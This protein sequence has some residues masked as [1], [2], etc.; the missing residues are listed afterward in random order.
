MAS[1]ASTGGTRELQFWVAD[2]FTPAAFAG[3]Q[4]AVYCLADE[5]VITDA[6]RQRIAAEHN[7]SETAYVT[8]PPGADA[9]G[10]LDAFKTGDTFGL[11]W[12][13][14]AAEVPLCGHATLASAHV[15]FSEVGNTSEALYFD[16]L[17]GRLTVRRAAGA[18]G[19][20]RIEMGLPWAD[21]RDPLP[22][23][24]GDAAAAGGGDA[25]ARQQALGSLVATATGGLG[26]AEPVGFTKGMDYFL[27]VLP[28]GTTRAQL[29]AIRPDF[30]AMVAAVGEGAARGAIVTARGDGGDDYDFYCRFFGPWVSIDE[31]PATGSAFCVLGPYW[32]PKLGKT[33]FKAR[34]CSPRGADVAVRLDSEAR[35]VYV[36]GQGVTTMKGTLLLPPQ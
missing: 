29:E 27:F 35:R 5:A 2:A 18:D 26:T 34:Q 24:L 25:D 1:Q 12:F 19:G 6:Q 31:D 23:G 13:T 11:R 3:N 36:S 17:S 4:A 9:G 7:L 16:T 15:L 28:E 21:A 10:G 33:Q 20:V 22:A 32:A 14:P 30:G 8:L